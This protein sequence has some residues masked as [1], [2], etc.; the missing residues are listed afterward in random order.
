VITGVACTKNQ[1]NV[2]PCTGGVGGD[3]SATA[4]NCTAYDSTVGGSVVPLGATMSLKLKCTDENG[5]VLSITSG[6]AFSGKINIRYYFKDEGASSI[7]RL[8]GN[9]FVKAG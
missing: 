8:S 3:Y 6:D 2:L 9:I 1:T 4:N 7:R 5:N